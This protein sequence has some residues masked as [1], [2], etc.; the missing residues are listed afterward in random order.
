[1]DTRKVIEE[2][3]LLEFGTAGIGRF[4]GPILMYESILVGKESAT[5]GCIEHLRI[6][7]QGIPRRRGGHSED[8]TSVLVP[9]CQGRRNEIGSLWPRTTA[10]GRPQLGQRRCESLELG[11]VLNLHRIDGLQ[12]TDTAISLAFMRALPSLGT[13]MARMIKMIAMT[14]RSSIS[15]KP[16]AR[17]RLRNCSMTT[18]M[19]RN[20][21]A[22][23]TPRFTT[24]PN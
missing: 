5:A 23:C 4:G 14:I 20:L 2:E 8:I 18:I 1:M 6:C 9:N 22:A 24:L 13:A 17:R 10:S 12:F 16:R 11:H 7:I 15:E 19:T 21:V 3:I